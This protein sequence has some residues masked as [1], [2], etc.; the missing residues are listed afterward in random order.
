[1]HQGLFG[2]SK[3]TGF[4]STEGYLQ[5]TTAYIYEILNPSNIKDFIQLIRN[6]YIS[7]TAME[8]V[9]Y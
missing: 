8:N 1:M 3:V 5:A 4:I 9:N 6:L 7:S 2:P